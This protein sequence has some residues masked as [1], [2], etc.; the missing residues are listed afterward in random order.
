MILLL[1]LWLVPDLGLKGIAVAQ[2]LQY[3][4]WLMLGWIMLRKYLPDLHFV[5]RRWSRSMFSE[6]WRY[7]LNLQ[8][9]SILTTLGDPLAKTLL[10]HFGG[11]SALGYFEMANRLALQVRAL[12]TAANQVL[13]PYYSKI[14]E[15]SRATLRT[16][17]ERNLE[18]TTLLSALAFSSIGTLLPLIS[19]L[20][21]GHV[22]RQFLLFAALLLAGHFVSTNAA[23][24]YFANL[25][26][27]WVSRNLVGNLTQT[28]AM[29]AF[30]VA[31]GLV[32]GARGI[33]VAYALSLIAGS[34]VILGVFHRAEGIR[35]S[36]IFSRSAVNTVGLGAATSTCGFVLYLLLFDSVGSPAAVLASTLALVAGWA[37]ILL[38]V[39]EFIS[40]GIEL[41]SRIRQRREPE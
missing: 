8:A 15:T 19:S 24:A 20:W 30:G 26:G 12:L 6:M 33:V 29:L 22:D 9:I 7:G 16:L 39:P 38:R 34:V 35:I 13:I 21:I 1:G 17:Y 4:V 40:L 23:P 31:G 37:M 25:G 28:I 14:T 3:C 10:S 11:L 32:D 27:G 2:L 36:A 18:V 5:P 41:D